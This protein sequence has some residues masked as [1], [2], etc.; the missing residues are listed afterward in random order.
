MH[1]HI[2]T[3][4]YH[5]HTMN[6]HIFIHMHR[7]SSI[8][9]KGCRA[10]GNLATDN[11]YN[12]AVIAQEGGASLIVAAMHAHEVCVCCIH[13]LMRSPTHTYMHSCTHNPAAVIAVN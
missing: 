5:A 7:E 8:Q 12:A 9:E 4:T 13:V 3:D 2:H 10:L 1:I 6:I 11:K